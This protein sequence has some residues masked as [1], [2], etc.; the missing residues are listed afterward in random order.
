MSATDFCNTG[1]PPS[2]AMMRWITEASSIS[3]II[4][5][6]ARLW[7]RF[8]DECSTLRNPKAPAAASGRKLWREEDKKKAKWEPED[9]RSAGVPAIGVAPILCENTGGWR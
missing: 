6:R 5:Q 4:L 2:R 8:D 7:Y 1:A 9:R 3:A